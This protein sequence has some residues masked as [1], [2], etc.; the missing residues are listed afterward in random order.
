MLWKSSII[1]EHFSFIYSWKFSFHLF[2][3][4]YFALCF[5]HGNFQSFISP[6]NNADQSCKQSVT[7]IQFSIIHQTILQSIWFV[8]QANNLSQANNRRTHS[9]YSTHQLSDN[10]WHTFIFHISLPLKQNIRSGS[11]PIK[12]HIYPKYSDSHA[13]QTV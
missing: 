4:I 2:M 7:Q 9:L 3:E 11:N 1:H 13:L 10:F 8:N 12:S 6:L 5:I